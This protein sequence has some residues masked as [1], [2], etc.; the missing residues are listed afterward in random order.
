MA[1][2]ETSEEVPE[3]GLEIDPADVAAKAEA[4]EIELIDVRRDYEHEA[5]HIAGSRN[6]EMNDLDRAVRTRSPRTARSSSTAAAAAALRWQPKRSRKR[7][8][9]LT[10]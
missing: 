3:T 4:G 6:I 2:T 1:D 7:A 10:T 5:G 8:S 9:T